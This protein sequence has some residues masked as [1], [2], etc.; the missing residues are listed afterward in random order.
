M[1]GVV[2]LIGER[3]APSW[4]HRMMDLA[5][6]RGPD[7]SGAC[8]FG[9]MTDG[10]SMGILGENVEQSAGPVLGLGHR[11][12]SILDTS[13]HGRQPMADSD[14]QIHISYN[15]EIYNYLELRKVLEGAGHQFTSQTDTEVLLAA[16]KEWGLGC[17]SRL[18]GM[19]A[20]LVVDLIKQEFW[21][22]R[23][24]FGIKP[25]YCWM[26][27][28][29]VVAFASEIKQFTDLPGW[30]A[31]FN[32]DRI[33]DFLVW[34]I[35]DHAV[36]TC[37]LGVQQIPPGSFIRMS[38]KPETTGKIK[39]PNKLGAQRWYEMNGDTW[40]QDESQAY[41]SFRDLLTK[42]VKLRLQAD[43]PVGSCLSGGIDSSSVV[44]LVN[45]LRGQSRVNRQAVFSAVSDFS[46]VDESN[47]IQQVSNH[48][49]AESYE[50]CP[51][52][53]KLFEVLPELVWHQDEPFGSTSIFAQWQVFKLAAEN[54]VKVILDGQGADELLAGYMGS[55]V[56]VRLA[57]LFLEWRWWQLVK[58]FGQFQKGTGLTGGRLT[59]QVMDLLL[60]VSVAM[61]VRQRLGYASLSPSWLNIDLLGANPRDPL[62]DTGGRCRSVNNLSR[63]QLMASSLQM[64]LRF[65]DRNSM[66]H[67]VEARLPFLDYRLV[68]C[69]LG[70]PGEL[71]ISGGWTKKLL[72]ESMRG[73]LPE[74]VRL[75][76][77]KIGFETA[78]K[79]WATG[80]LKQE[81]LH[82][83]KETVGMMG[84]IVNAHAITRV[85][86][87]LE[88][89]EPYGTLPWRL[90][91]LGAWMKRHNVALN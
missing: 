68:E 65:E 24:R 11:R 7:D 75:R 62:R 81:F 80:P 34:G 52:R 45:E 26:S 6:H 9:R 73:I 89:R 12:L 21:A 3:L 87:M 29:G 40:Q 55:F 23:D 60:P 1:C 64:L 37:F 32:S 16:W 25:M 19:F 53:D 31:C 77:D 61:P 36:D 27:P 88:G 83:V 30:R 46:R 18:N 50:V 79:E 15:G 35:T 85:E 54:G 43:V 39:W 28:H 91:C 47:W 57:E 42:S 69:V 90:I 2:G 70:M 84:G 58:E 41:C 4:V 82:H 56:P 51:S 72:R 33:Y 44:C 8:F 10:H 48:V 38:L 13:N 86:R 71:K 67:S 5:K 66:A 78:E 63:S 49:R 20:F 76:R 59:M 22:V 74:P 14:G 17:L